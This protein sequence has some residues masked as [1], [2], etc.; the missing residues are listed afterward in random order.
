[1]VK[2]WRFL[3]LLLFSLVLIGA[4]SC[5]S[6][7]GEED[8]GDQFT[9]VVRDDLIITVS[10]TGNI[11]ASDDRQ[12]SF[13]TGGKIERILVEEGDTVSE[14]QVLAELET[15]ALELAVKQG[16]VA[17]TQ[18]QLA[19]TQARL[20]IAQAQFSIDSA[21]YDLEFTE[22]L[23]LWTEISA[24]QGELADA[25]DY[26]ASALNKLA[27]APPGTASQEAWQK[28]VFYA[29]LRLKTARNRVDAMV[30]GTDTEQLALKR[31]QL[32]LSEQA[33]EQARQSEEQTRQSEEL[34][35]QSL[36]QAEKQLAEA[37]LTAPF[38][39]IVTDVKAEEGDT[40]TPA[41]PVF[42]LI[43][44]RQMELNVDVDEVDIANV[45]EGQDVLLE[46]DALPEMTVKGKVS[47]IHELPKKEGGVILYR[48]RIEFN[49]PASSRVRNGMS[50]N[51]D[52][53]LEERS[54]VLLVPNRAI[55]QNSR[56]ESVV[57][58]S[59]DEEREETEERI[60]VTGISD[61]YLTEITGGLSEGE[62]VVERRR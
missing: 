46:L 53:I 31:Q 18:A 8:K 23:H 6:L 13:G 59:L 24:T 57:E 25:E 35:R 62:T 38:S 58:I 5:E 15:D 22:D 20:A 50:A 27:L 47:Y 36:A 60:V 26:L 54:G 2:K 17:L 28:A 7:T 33:L 14:G 51:A 41:M 9:E 45:I 61:G 32:G 11:E 43:D 30:G 12:L 37:V 56:G 21:E 52:I 1:M 34:A 3:A 4:T 48:V 40:V 19:V 29:E 10:G 16:Q 44:N 55:R 39:G 49:V 42:R